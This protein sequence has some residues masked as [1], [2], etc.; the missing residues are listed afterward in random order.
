LPG[1]ST[2]FGFHATWAEGNRL[3][4]GLLQAAGVAVVAAV[5]MYWWPRVGAILALASACL[6]IYA[7][8]SIGVAGTGKGLVAW[9]P[10]VMLLALGAALA[11]RRPKR[12]G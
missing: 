2:G 8:A 6:C 1:P 12:G 11:L 5:L 4:L 9:L 3:L 10:P 7:L